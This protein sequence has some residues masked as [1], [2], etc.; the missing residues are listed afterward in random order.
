MR[1]PWQIWSLF[2]LCL[3][4]VLPAMAWLTHQ[5]LAADRAEW[6]A[7]WHAEREETIGSVLWQMDTQLTPLLAQEAARPHFV[8]SSFY[9]APTVLPGGNKVDIPQVKAKL[10]TTPAEWSARQLPS[11][12]LTQSSPYVLLHFQMNAEGQLTSPQVPDERLAKLA[13]DQGVTT[14]NPELHRAR[15]EELQQS[16]TFQRVASLLPTVRVTENGVAQWQLANANEIAAP[17]RD[18]LS[19]GN[20]LEYSQVKEELEVAQN[21]EFT[22]ANGPPAQQA[23]PNS[24]GGAQNFL[25]NS[26]QSRAAND[27]Q[28]R[29]QAYQSATQ[30]QVLEQRWNYFAA[31]E[32]KYVSEGINQPIWL[33]GRLLLARRVNVGDTEIIQGCWL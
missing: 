27:L 14:C 6:L 1:R 24:Q 18:A 31:P 8:Y 12:L 3:A 29:N 13:A 25:T 17:Q 2:V 30:R 20:A 21:E 16:V 19:V 26:R 33:D 28:Q 32:L 7:R 9:T 23:L 5:T 15:L 22:A 11:P 4:I 10:A